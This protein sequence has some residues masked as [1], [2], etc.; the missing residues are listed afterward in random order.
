MDREVFVFVV[1][2]KSY[3][4]NY[5]KTSLI[6]PDLY[7]WKITEVKPSPLQR[8]FNLTELEILG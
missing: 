3:T 8:E 7:F 2:E 6:R 5:V 4:I 1:Q